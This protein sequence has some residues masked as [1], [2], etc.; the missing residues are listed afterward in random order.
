DAAHRL[1]FLDDPMANDE[2]VAL[3]K[4]GGV[5]WN[6]W[7]CE[8]PDIRPDLSKADLSGAYLSGAYLDGAKLTGADLS[9]ANLSGADLEGADLGGANVVHL[10]EYKT[11]RVDVGA[12]AIDER[13]WPGA[14]LIWRQ[15]G[16]QV[17]FVH[18]SA[19]EE[20]AQ[21]ELGYLNHRGGGWKATPILMR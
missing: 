16:D 4:K 15:N 10:D 20:S 11:Q 12:A 18:L 14:W 13:P 8:N 19:T 7:R 5:A 9:K 2:H 6:A 21:E 3:L 1:T 17:E